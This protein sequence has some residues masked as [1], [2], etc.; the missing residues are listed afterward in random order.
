MQ[1][2]LLYLNLIAA[3]AS[4]A[5]GLIAL[6]RPAALSAS[7]EVAGGEMFYARMYAARAIPFG[8]TAEILPLL[9]AG[10]A[11]A[12]VLFTA[13]LIQIADVAIGVGKK[14]QRMMLG[15][16]LGAAVHLVCGIMLV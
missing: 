8:L 14:E 2:V 16:S 4:A 10:L 1:I 7:N 12:W 13:A 5:A 15:A 9:S 3:F 6:V 11:V